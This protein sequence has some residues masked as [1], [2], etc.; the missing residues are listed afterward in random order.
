MSYNFQSSQKKE[1][2]IGIGILRV[3][4]SFMVI[5]DHLYDRKKYPAYIYFLCY[6]IPT[7]FLLSFFYTSKTLKSF[8]IN[9]I[10]MRLERIIIPYFSWYII[11]WIFNNIYFYLFNINKSHSLKDFIYNLLNG[12][13]FNAALWFQIILILL[14]IIFLIIIF[15]FKN[16]YMNILVTLGIL[17]YILQYTGLNYEFFT[18]YFPYH[19]KITY[20]RI[21]EG[22]P[23]AI[24]GFYISSNNLMKLL[25]NNIRNTITN[26]II[27]L[28]FITKLKVFLDI[29][30]F[31]YGGIRLNIGA[32]CF[33][34]IFFFFPSKKIKNEFLI[35]IIIKLTNYTGGIYFL[36]ILIGRGYILKKIFTILTI[37]RHT[38]FHCI[39]VFIISHILCLFGTKLFGRTKFKHLFA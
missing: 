37:K 19:Y 20:G 4:L 34:F 39:T 9:K 25:K 8:N 33:L 21:A 23:H 28:I 29:D 18:N 14:T 2:N 32:I 38:I 15:L 27:I 24:T 5:I 16:Y 11:Y 7:F 35:K 6:H 31:K 12:R 36:H 10:K 3:F 17:S 22:F 13:S 30:T 26:S 1:Y